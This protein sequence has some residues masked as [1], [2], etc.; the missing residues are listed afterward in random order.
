M[1]YQTNDVSDSEIVLKNKEYMTR[2]NLAVSISVFKN[3]SK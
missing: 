3:H 1:K 2:D